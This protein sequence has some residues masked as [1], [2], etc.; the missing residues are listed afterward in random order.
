MGGNGQ[1]IPMNKIDEITSCLHSLYRINNPINREHLNELLSDATTEELNESLLSTIA[2]IDFP[3]IK[4]MIEAGADPRYSNDAFFITC[5]GRSDPAAMLYFIN[6]HGVDVNTQDGEGLIEACCPIQFDVIKVLLENGATIN[7][8]VIEIATRN[9]DMECIDFLLKQGI[10]P[11]IIFKCML[12]DLISYG[13]SRIHLRGDIIGSIK[14]IGKHS[15]EIDLG[16]VIES[17]KQ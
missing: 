5:C 14:L 16:K 13:E 15:N 8:R 9:Y 7:S 3:L 6:E 4:L 2:Y 11:G 10:D 17:I 1:F 12:K